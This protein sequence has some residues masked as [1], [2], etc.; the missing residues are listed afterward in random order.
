MPD[1]LLEIGAEEIPDWMLAP[2]LEHL[3]AAFSKLLEDNK[4]AGKVEWVD[5]TPRRL[6]LLAVKLPK[7]QK[8]SVE[9]VMGPPK[10]AGEGAAQGFARKNGAGVEQL[11]TLATPKGDYFSLKKQVAGRTTAA[12]LA[13]A[14]PALILGIPWPKSMYWLGKGT[15]RFIRPLRWICALLGS[16][17]VPFEV[18]G[19]A[20]SNRTHGHRKFGKKN[21]KVSIARYAA[22]LE[23]NH[24]LIRA[25]DR[26]ARIESAIA[27]LVEGKGLRVKQDEGLLETVTYLTEWPTP[28][29]GSFDASYLELPAE[30]LVTVMRH[31][32]K[33]FSVE[34]EDGT[35]APHFIAVLNTLGDPGGLIVSGNERVLRA[36]F[37]DARFF[38]R[39]DQQK[40]LRARV[41]DLKAVT[42]QRDLGSYHDKFEAMLAIL[43]ELAA[44]EAARHAAPLAKC[45][46]TCEM[47]KE[48]TEL[49]G[50]VG[51]LYAKAQGE[52]DEV[53]TAIYDQYKPVSMEDSIPRNAPGQYLALADKLHSLRGCFR[54]GLIPTGSKDPLA[55][56]RAAQGVVK[57]LTEGGLAVPFASL[58]GGDAKLNEFLMDRL[59]YYFRD[60]RGFAHGEL[61]AV[62]AAGIS[63]LPDVLARLEAIRA[64]RPTADFEPLAA[65]FKRIRNILDQAGALATNTVEAALF[66]EEPERN[67]D[68]AASALH[69]AGLDHRTALERIATLRPAVDAFFDKVLVN[70]P[71]PAVRANRLALLARILTEFSTIA[72]FSEIVTTA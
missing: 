29:L 66:S 5:A 38:W 49:Q 26:R 57:I 55:L 68:A 54:L 17:V 40:P 61:N 31:H 15:P 46:L 56:R 52:S 13:E 6:A 63:T 23:A 33:N 50:V 32:Q 53:A 45:D 28:I 37:N 60:V 11:E 7:G 47:V 27:A 3:R 44:P 67:L 62:L 18:A 69:L 43:D 42:F 22:Q 71:E 48:F 70:A 16:E 19:V 41:E 39:V 14:L 65:S 2:A 20:S 25:A 10:S 9:V 35:L 8:D 34:R 36:R 58:A 1:F 30:V 51:G 24:V 4:L 64:V 59:R 21:I 72:D 12:I